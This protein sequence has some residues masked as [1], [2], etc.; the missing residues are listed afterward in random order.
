MTYQ[1]LLDTLR[2]LPECYLAQAVAYGDYNQYILIDNVTIT[3]STE[4]A[5]DVSTPMQG[6][7]IVQ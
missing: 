5:G 3:F 1:E 4:L 7:L 2:E 6:R